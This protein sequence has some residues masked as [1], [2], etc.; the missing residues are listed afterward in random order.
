MPSNERSCAP[1][2]G[3]TTRVCNAACAPTN[4]KPAVL[5]SQPVVDAAP[6][7]GTP[8]WASPAVSSASLTAGTTANTEPASSDAVSASGCGGVLDG[9]SRHATAPVGAGE[10]R[11]RAEV[12]ADRGRLAAD[13]AGNRDRR[14]RDPDDGTGGGAQRGGRGRISRVRGR[15][16]E[17]EPG[18]Q[19]GCHRRPCPADPTTP[20]YSTATTR[21]H[22]YGTFTA[23]AVPL[24]ATSAPHGVGRECAAGNVV[25]PTVFATVVGEMVVGR[26][27]Q[28]RA[29]EVPARLL[30]RGEE[31]VRRPV[32]RDD[33]LVDGQAGRHLLDVGHELVP[34]PGWSARSRWARSASSRSHRSRGR[35]GSGR[36]GS[37][38]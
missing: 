7:N 34:S 15:A 1:Q 16:D 4:P 5:P 38:W 31:Q 33:R 10:A 9:A 12:G 30:H 26:L 24:L 19:R 3:L 28:R 21:P 11:L 2:A 32:A 23:N 8:A 20:R 29:G 27:H 22:V 36:T 35:R 25:G 37:D 6:T 14:A 17:R 13:H 18:H